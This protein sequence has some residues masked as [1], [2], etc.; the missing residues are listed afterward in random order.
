MLQA[1]DFLVSLAS[2]PNFCGNDELAVCQRNTS[3][4]SDLRKSGLVW[5]VVRV[6]AREALSLAALAL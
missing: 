1:V 6:L 5:N 3:L 4:R 2:E